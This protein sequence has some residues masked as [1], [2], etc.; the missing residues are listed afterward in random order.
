MLPLKEYIYFRTNYIVYR[1]LKKLID[2]VLMKYTK[3]LTKTKN[4]KLLL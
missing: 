3:I 4:M 1:E 2:H